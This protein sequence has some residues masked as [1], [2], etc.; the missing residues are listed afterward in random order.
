MSK[1]TISKEALFSMSEDE[2][3]NQAQLSYFDELIRQQKTFKKAIPY[4]FIP[5]TIFN[6]AT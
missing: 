2:Y 5:K 1:S 4:E 6:P 3:M